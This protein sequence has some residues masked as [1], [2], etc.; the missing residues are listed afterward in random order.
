MVDV[1][2]GGAFIEVFLKDKVQ[3]GLKKIEGRVREFGR[4]LR[5]TGLAGLG[6]TTAFTFSAIFPVKAAADFERSLL[7]IRAAADNLSED[8]LMKLNEFMRELGKTSNFT[9]QEIGKAAEGLARSINGPNAFAAIRD[10][11][12][13]ILNLAIATEEDPEQVATAVIA[14]LNQFNLKAT[15]AA[16]VADVL[17]VAA[18]SSVASVSDIAEAFKF[19]GTDLGQSRVTLEEASALVAGLN[20]L[21]I[22]GTNAGTALRRLTTLSLSSAREIKDIFNIDIVDANEQLK[23]PIEIFEE[24]VR[25]GEKLGDATF[26]RKLEQAFGILGI[27]AARGIGQTADGIREI[28]A[29]I[30]NSEGAAKRQADTILGGLAGSLRRINASFQTFL[31]SVGE[32]FGSVL[33]GIEPLLRV[34][35]TAMSDWVAANPKLVGSILAVV[36]VVGT[37]SAALAVA[38]FAVQG[39]GAAIG[40]LGGIVGAVASALGALSGLGLPAL[41]LAINVALLAMTDSGRELLRVFAAGPLRA[42]ARNLKDAFNLALDT[43]GESLGRI[44]ELLM[45]GEYELAAE[46]AWAAVSRVIKATLQDIQDTAR[47]TFNEILEYLGFTADEAEF[48]WL[49]FSKALLGIFDLL[50][51]QIRNHIALFRLFLKG[52]DI[53]IDQTVSTIR[54]L[55]ARIRDLANFISV[56]LGLGLIT[57]NLKTLNQGIKALGTNADNMKASFKSAG[58]SASQSLALAGSDAK[59][60]NEGIEETA[61]KVS[62]GAVEGATEIEKA[63]QRA[64]DKVDRRLAELRAKREEAAKQQQGEDPSPSDQVRTAEKSIRAISDLQERILDQAFARAER[65]EQAAVEAATEAQL[66][67]ER[68]GDTRNLDRILEAAQRASEARTRAGQARDINNFEEAIREAMRAEL[69]ANL[70]TSLDKQQQLINDLTDT[71]SNVVGGFNFRALQLQAVQSIDSQMLSVLQEIRNILSTFESRDLV[72]RQ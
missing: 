14:T 18:N 3:A 9:A 69:F 50:A 49:S 63:Y 44:L 32:A 40:L 59:T 39:I 11:L 61:Q 64:L 41:V 46:L 12:E 37:L 8:E 42:I 25:A 56:G 45:S 36:G 67:A 71:V 16:R 34:V 20:Q 28:F 57:D 52:L 17:T 47:K 53:A 15:E 30:Q 51:Q 65:A 19:S 68:T 29:A 5:T 6:F 54:D 33:T 1:K 38:G 66:R 4:K 10:S 27:T 70:G 72:F 23:S 26:T 7:V 58:L 48:I 22:S 62:E 24:I 43:A 21:G 31:I 13:P 2:A 55:I 60:L 35:L